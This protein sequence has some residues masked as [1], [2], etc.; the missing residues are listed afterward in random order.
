MSLKRT[1]FL[2]I[3][4]H[5]YSRW[6]AEKLRRR[7][8][9]VDLVLIDLDDCMYPGTTNLTLLRN[10]FV[11]LLY[12]RK[13]KVLFRLIGYLPILFLLKCLQLFGL[14]VDNCKLI[15]FFCQMVKSI[16][17]FY[18]QTAAQPIPCHS[19]AG[20]KE[21]LAVLSKKS[22]I[23]LISLGLDIVL[24]EYKKQFR[25]GK[26]LI[27]FYNG[28]QIKPLKL[29]DKSEKTRER[30]KEFNAQTPLIIG[31]NKDDLGAMKVG[32]EK[33]GLILG[34]NPSRKVIGQ[35]DIIVK[36]KDWQPLVGYLI[37]KALF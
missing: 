36:A 26:P 5:I 37:G 33:G 29:I 17:F 15:L 9:E 2:E 25:D 23:G 6:E 3:A 7:L 13:Y 18:L 27:D 30:I 4:P 21:S 11:L 34:F 20:T 19:F 1:G 35:C 8:R 12:R 10:L 31:H 24:E 32:K 22:K 14:G 16:P 28:T